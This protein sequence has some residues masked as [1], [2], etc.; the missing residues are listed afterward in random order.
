MRIR[1]NIEK[2]KRKQRELEA[3]DGQKGG[4]SHF[5]CKVHRTIDKNYELIRRSKTML[6]SLNDSQADF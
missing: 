1:I 3:E 6:A 4:K 5:G 2:M